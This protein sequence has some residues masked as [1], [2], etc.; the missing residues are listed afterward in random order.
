MAAITENTNQ[1]GKAVRFLENVTITD[2][3]AASTTVRKFVRV[4]SWARFATL[5]LFHQSAGGTAPSLNIL[6]EVP[7]I[8][9]VA[10]LSAPDDGL[11]L[12]LGNFSFTAITGTGPY[13]QQIHMGPGIADDNT[14]SATADASYGID[15]NLPPLLA[16]AYV[17][18]GAG[19]ALEDYTFQ[20]VLHFRK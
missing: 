17:T 20:L 2:Q 16:Y 10:L 1:Q 5:Y 8:K 4:P 18:A 3:A 11:L 14:G 9:T 15:A 19:V 6:L 7:D 13:V 12:T